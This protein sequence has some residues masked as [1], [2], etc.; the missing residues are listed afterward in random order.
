MV[1]ATTLNCRRRVAAI[2]AEMHTYED[3]GSR[4]D[5]TTG[6]KKTEES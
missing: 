4:I 6:S 1:G 2:E 3:E 5:G